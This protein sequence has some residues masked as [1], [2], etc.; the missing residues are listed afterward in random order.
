MNRVVSIVGARPQFIKAA[1]V[2]R[3]LAEHAHV[4]EILV[5]TGQH[6][7]DNMSEIFFRHMN[8]ARPDY[9]LGVNSLTHAAMTGQMLHKIEP[10]LS[11]EKPD[12]VLVYGDTNTT[13]AAALAAVKLHIPIGHVEAGL[14]SFNRLMPEEI[15]RVVA[16]H[17]SDYLFAPTETAVDNLK[18]EG[19][20]E[21]KI[22]LTGDVM[23]DAA[24][25]YSEVCETESDILKALKI[26]PK[27]YAL[28]TLHRAENTDH[29]ERLK[30]IF[31]GLIKAAEKIRIVLPLHPRTKIALQRI[32][33]FESIKDKL[34]I[35][36]PVGYLDMVKLEKYSRVIVTDSG[37][38]QKEAYFFKIP[39]ITLRNETE[40][41]ELVSIGWNRLVSTNSAEEISQSIVDAKPPKDSKI[42]N[43]FGEGHA[44][45][46]I[47]TE[48]LAL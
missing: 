20:P 44:S 27:D 3:A 33:L 16:D 35:I 8:I 43:I 14:R 26:V 47:V 38:V 28:L 32:G 46:N 36:D 24:L 5:H 9:N 30:A 19:I 11:S 4:R 29:T 31:D 7:D 10:L 13:L 39:C 42:K 25:Y 45:Q 12:I 22:F 48:I 17:L 15:N 23:Y 2:G 6:F 37:G 1:M 40:W 21:G 18:H 34:I 41:V